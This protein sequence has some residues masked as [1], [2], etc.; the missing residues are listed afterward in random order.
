MIWSSLHSLGRGFFS[1]QCTIQVWGLSSFLC[2]WY[3]DKVAR[4]WSWPPRDAEHN[5]PLYPFS[6]VS[7]GVDTGSSPLCTFLV[8]VA[9]SQYIYIY[10]SLYIMYS[11]EIWYFLKIQFLVDISC[12]N[13]SW[14]AALSSENDK[15]LL[16][17]LLWDVEWC[18]LVLG[19]FCW[20]C[21]GPTCYPE[22]SQENFIV[23]QCLNCYG[24]PTEFFYNACPG[25]DVCVCVC[26]CVHACVC[27]CAP[28]PSMS[29]KQQR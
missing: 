10:I 19:T 7:Y 24:G 23:T 17:W 22:L 26:A 8:S 27:M 12:S 14:S 9:K 21:L 13:E 28:L 16:S 20:Q 1:S 11:Y 2:I 29:I 15:I 4:A 6:C 18:V 3:Q 5:E 25:G